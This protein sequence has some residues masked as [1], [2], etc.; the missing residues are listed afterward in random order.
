VSARG[1][2]SGRGACLTFVSTSVCLTVANEEAAKRANL[3]GVWSSS[4]LLMCRVSSHTFVD[5]QGACLCG[6]VWSDSTTIV[7]NVMDKLS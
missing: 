3:D 5:V 4:S 1:Q 6:C 7:N 2:R